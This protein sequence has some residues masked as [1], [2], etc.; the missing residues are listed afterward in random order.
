MQSEDLRVLDAARDWLRRGET[1]YLCTVVG[2]FGS[3][4]R[5]PGSLLAWCAEFGLSGSLSGGCVEDELVNQLRTG[6]FPEFPQLLK[7]GVTAEENARLGL[8]CGGSL[9]VFVERLQPDSD[10]LAH[11][12]KVCECLAGRQLLCREVELQSGQM[13]LREVDQHSALSLSDGL[14]RH[15][16]GP[17]FRLILVGA[18]QLSKVL[19][20]MASMLDYRVLVV[21]PR[22]DFVDTW[23]VPDS[24]IRQGMPDDMVREWGCDSNTAVLTLTHDPRIDDMALLEALASEAFYVGALGSSRTTEKRLERLRQLGMEEQQIAALHAPIGLPIGSKTPAE[25]AIAILAQLTQL[26]RAR[27]VR[28]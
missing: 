3:S 9:D 2:T 24:E 20:E 27:V 12:E 19:A 21:D 8:P 11:I 10:T 28:D 13:T 16:Y 17:A 1:V 15:V 18:G 4:P 22:Q 5:P 6:C 7:Y 14:L 25:I 26:R 23:A